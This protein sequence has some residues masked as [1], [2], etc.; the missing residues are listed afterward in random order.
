VRIEPRDGVAMN[1]SAEFF[2]EAK[3]PFYD[4]A[5]KD[6]ELKVEYLT[7]HFQRM[8]TRRVATRLA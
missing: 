3:K 4:F 7:S 5:L 1:A 6:Y 2:D 8:C